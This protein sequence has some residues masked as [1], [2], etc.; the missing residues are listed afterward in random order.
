VVLMTKLKAAA[1]KEPPM[2]PVVLILVAQLL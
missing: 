1:I 2:L